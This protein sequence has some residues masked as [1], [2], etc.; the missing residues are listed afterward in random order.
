MMQTIAH[1]RH[2]FLKSSL[3]Q[4]YQKANI[5][6]LVFDRHN[7]HFLRL[8]FGHITCG[9]DSLHPLAELN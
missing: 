5:S 1:K 6:L 4:R 8:Q 3:L 2:S 9:K 7:G